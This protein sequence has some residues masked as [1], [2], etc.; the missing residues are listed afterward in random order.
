MG[1]QHLETKRLILRVMQP[2][3][4]DGLKKIFG[5]PKVMASFNATPFND[6]QMR[7]WLEGRLNHQARHGYS[8]FSVILKSEGILIG[9]CGLENMEL[10][11][12]HETELGYDFRSDYW[13]QGY[14][15]EAASAVRDF[16][17]DTLALP[18]LISLIRVGNEA[19]R[20]V[21]Q[22]I[23]MQKM[24]EITLSATAY[25][26]YGMKAPVS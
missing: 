4:F 15:T 14:A 16:A 2:S 5:D 19:S 21:S 24:D 23:G 8:L 10:E 17:F 7:S 13:N 11:S 9:D 12:G 20:R 26:K 6:E 22:K 3:D 25:W 18:A 1:E